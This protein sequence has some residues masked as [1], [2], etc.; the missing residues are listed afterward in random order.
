MFPITILHKRLIKRFAR[1]FLAGSISA[2]LAIAPLSPENYNWHDLS[3]WLYSLFF[4]FIVGGI[5]GLIMSADLYL[6]NRN[7]KKQNK[8]L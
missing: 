8:I 2:M 4:A 3:T 6:R 7:D 1:A 5:S